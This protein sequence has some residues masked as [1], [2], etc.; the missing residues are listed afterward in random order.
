MQP[1]FFLRG[2]HPDE[3]DGAPKEILLLGDVPTVKENVMKKS[4]KN[5]EYKK[6][7]PREF[8]PTELGSAVFA[9]V[10][11]RPTDEE[12][13]IKDKRTR[14]DVEDGASVDQEDP[15]QGL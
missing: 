14:D 13:L 1:L 5:G 3:L 15:K 9:S 7:M 10:D 8:I 6:P 12:Y 4:R 11:G 2:S